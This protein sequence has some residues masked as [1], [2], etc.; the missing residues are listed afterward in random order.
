MEYISNKP[1]Q[2][3]DQDRKVQ[4]LK[5]NCLFFR[6]LSVDLGPAGVSFPQSLLSV[7]TAAVALQSSHLSMGDQS[8]S[9][10]PYE[11]TFSE[12]AD[13]RENPQQWHSRSFYTR[14]DG[15]RMCI[16]IFPEGEDEGKD[17][18]VSIYLYMMKVS[19]T[20]P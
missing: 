6:V 14:A 20:T 12:Y 8:D 4:F 10:V 5:D 1:L 16:K 15:Y 18:H 19:M 13:K 11:F 2:K 17:T 9:V 7:P 3:Y